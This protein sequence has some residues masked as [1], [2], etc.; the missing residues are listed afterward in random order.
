MKIESIELDD[1]T[2]VLGLTPGAVPKGID[3]ANDRRRIDDIFMSYLAAT[4]KGDIIEIGTSYGRGTCILAHNTKHTVHTI[5]PLPKHHTGQITLNMTKKDIGKYYKK[6]GLNNICQYYGSSTDWNY[7]GP[8]PHFCFIDGCHDKNY[9]YLDGVM[10]EKIISKDGWIV[11]HDFD[12]DS[13]EYWIREVVGGVR[14]WA[15]D[16][17]IYHLKGSWMGAWKSQ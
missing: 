3:P 11:W 5:N 13:K 17:K 10:C 14:Q 15:G 2:K 12:P 4:S 7:N 16:R 6:M 1:L 9:A 8:A